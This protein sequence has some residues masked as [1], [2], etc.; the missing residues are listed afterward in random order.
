MQLLQH[1]RT[2]L[3]EA[4]GLR[5]VPLNSLIAEEAAKLRAAHNLSSPDAIQM[6][7]AL[8]E[9][10]AAFLTN[11]HRLPRLPSLPLL[12]ADNL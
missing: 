10:A 1:Y 9:G 2:I 6:A 11:D 8:T 4:I 5:T 3:R 12:L 7:T